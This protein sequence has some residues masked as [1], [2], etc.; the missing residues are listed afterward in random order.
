MEEGQC[1][2]MLTYPVSHP[3]DHFLSVKEFTFSEHLGSAPTSK[4]V[5]G[6]EQDST[7]LAHVVEDS[8]KSWKL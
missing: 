5:I 3:L 8:W 7:T 6:I 2:C 4:Q 1:A